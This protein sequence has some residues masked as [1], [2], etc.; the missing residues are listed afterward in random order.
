LKRTLEAKEKKM[1]DDLTKF[2][3]AVEKYY[4]TYLTDPKYMQKID[5]VLLLDRDNKDL[6]RKKRKY[7][8]KDD[9]SYF[10]K[11][12]EKYKNECVPAPCV[13][14]VHKLP[15]QTQAI[16]IEGQENS[17]VN[18]EDLPDRYEIL[19]ISTPKPA[20]KRDRRLTPDDEIWTIMPYKGLTPEQKYKKY[21]KIL[22]QMRKRK[23][24]L[25]QKRKEARKARQAQA[26]AMERKKQEQRVR[27]SS[28]KR[29]N[30]KMI[31]EPLG[32]FWSL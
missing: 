7:V 2:F 19:E 18:I 32:I 12:V 11:L 27:T 13:I 10:L 4:L 20:P 14:T 17:Q 29:N 28:R 22:I 3:K 8:K 6:L 15:K 9:G 5:P 1:R 26:L 30:K 24:N 31:D 16:D 21:R 23:N 25:E